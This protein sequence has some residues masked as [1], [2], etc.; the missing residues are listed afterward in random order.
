[1]VAKGPVACLMPTLRRAVLLVLALG[2]LL[3]TGCR[4][5]PQTN[6]KSSDEAAAAGAF[7]RGWL[8][9]VLRHGATGISEFHDLDSNHGGATF[10]YSD[11]LADLVSHSCSQLAPED[12]VSSPLNSWP[13]FVREHPNAG[14]LASRGIRVYRC[15]AFQ[16]AL[17]SSSNH[18]GLLWH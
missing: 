8:P 5:T 17:D 12:E 4:E 7:A 10:Q 13:A 11:S 2:P 14:S 1:M 6:Y 18:A 16:V 9:E 3:V 15:E